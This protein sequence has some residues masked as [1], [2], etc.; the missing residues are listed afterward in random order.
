MKEHKKLKYKK[1]HN[2]QIITFQQP[3]TSK[4]FQVQAQ[5]ENQQKAIDTIRRNKII[6]FSGPAGCGKT[7]ISVALAVE[8]LLA[9]RID[10]IVITRPTVQA[11]E[12]LGFLPGDMES[13]LGPYLVPIFEELKEYVTEQEVFQWKKEGKLK[14]VPVAFMR[15]LNFHNTFII[16]DESQNL[17]YDQLVMLLT[18]FGRNSR[19]I[20][21]G[22]PMQSDLRRHEEGAFDEIMYKL[23]NVPGIG[24]AKLDSSDI[25]REPIVSLIL[26]ALNS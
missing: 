12:D 25:I 1:P 20:V 24:V 18:R 23:E 26:D 19:M 15:G 14:I 9:E 2:D 5:T 3:K 10:R 16:A 4:T 17:T 13:K 7:H 6:F 8:E 22:D 21:N 11:G